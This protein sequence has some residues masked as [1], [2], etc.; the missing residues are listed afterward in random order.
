[1][2]KIIFPEIDLTGVKGVMIDLDNTLYLYE[3]C[4][5]FALKS[6]FEKFFLGKMSFTEFADLYKKHRDEVTASLSPQ[7]ACRS[8][9]FAFQ[10]L[11]EDMQE[12][13]AYEKAAMLDQLYWHDFISVMKL[14][15]DAKKFLE[16]CKDR[17]LPI[18]VVTDMLAETQVKKLRK[19]QITQFIDYLVT[20]EEAGR[21]KPSALIFEVALKKLRLEKSEVIMIGDD[22]KKDV[23]GAK[24]NG[25]NSYQVKISK[26]I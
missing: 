24:N 22:E 26:E 8:R 11:L 14:E 25:I 4:H 13:E 21:E 18:C 12:K 19:L 20:S 23:V 5:N 2:Q 7:G 10:H 17:S 6:C 3:P 1:M 16:K 15:D 9:L